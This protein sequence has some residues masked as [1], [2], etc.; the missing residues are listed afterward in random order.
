MPFIEKLPVS[1]AQ[2]AEALQLDRQELA[3]TKN[4]PRT[5]HDKNGYGPRESHTHNLPFRARYPTDSS[6][7]NSGVGPLFLHA[8]IIDSISVPRPPLQDTWKVV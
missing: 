7:G 2:A 5:C 8:C 1:G 3:P 4:C 6:R